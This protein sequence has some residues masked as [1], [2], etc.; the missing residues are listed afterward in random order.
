MAASGIRSIRYALEIKNV[1]KVL[2]NDY[3][4]A[5]IESIK[6][7]SKANGVESIVEPSFNDAW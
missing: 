2:A 6:E 4:K 7:N 1:E 3:S 5:A